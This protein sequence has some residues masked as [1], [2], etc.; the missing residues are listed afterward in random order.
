M[1]HTHP[2]PGVLAGPNEQKDAI[3]VAIAPMEAAEI[4]SPGTH[5]MVKDGK[6]MRGSPCVG[7]IDPFLK[8]NV[9]PGDRAWLFLYPGTITSLRHDWSHP[10]FAAPADTPAPMQPS[11]TAE[12]ALRAIAA[13]LDIGYTQLLAAADTWL[14][15]GEHEVQQGR[16]SWRD[17]FPAYADEFWRLYSAL[18][19]KD[20]PPEKRTSFFCCS[21]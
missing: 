12:S 3:H 2:T 20:V 8:M 14:E 17:E 7:I 13:M 5:V 19:G 4:M 18:T 10:A 6:M 9:Q 15:T 16:D 11:P 1:S 21:C